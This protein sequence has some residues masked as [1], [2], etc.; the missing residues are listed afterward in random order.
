[1]SKQE[2][3][4]AFL[5]SVA[6]NI[7][8]S[9]LGNMDNLHVIRMVAKYLSPGVFIPPPLADTVQQVGVQ[10]LLSPGDGGQVPLQG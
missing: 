8:W 3:G 7:E 4:K 6:G 10:L 1:M 2:V 5:I 9:K